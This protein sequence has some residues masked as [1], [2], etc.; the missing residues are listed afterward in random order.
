MVSLMVTADMIAMKH[1]ASLFFLF[2]KPFVKPR[3]K[4]FSNL[5]NLVLKFFCVCALGSRNELTIQA[6]AKANHENVALSP[7]F[8]FQR[9]NGLLWRPHG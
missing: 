5:F 6:G 1:E 2:T 8:S 3:V 9:S 4:S 7:S